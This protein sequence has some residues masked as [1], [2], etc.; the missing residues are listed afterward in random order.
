MSSRSRGRRQPL[1][2]ALTGGIATGKSYVRAQFEKLGVPTIDAD[3]LA[4]TVVEPGTRALNEIVNAFGGEVLDTSGALDRKKLG[5][6]VFSDE[7]RRRTLEQI[8]HPE[9]RRA[10]D[11]WFARLDPSTPFAIADIPLLY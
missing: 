4:R 6:V 8:V 3:I 5:A 7:S 2:I 1:R 10:T 11:E 9:V